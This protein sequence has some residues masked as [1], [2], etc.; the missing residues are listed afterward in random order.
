MRAQNFQPSTPG[1]CGW[2]IRSKEYFVTLVCI[3]SYGN[4]FTLALATVIIILL[5]FLPTPTNF[6]ADVSFSNQ[7]ML[8]FKCHSLYAHVCKYYIGTCSIHGYSDQ[9]TS[10]AKVTPTVSPT[11]DTSDFVTGIKRKFKS[12]CHCTTYLIKMN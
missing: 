9:I 4:Q 3:N 12:F 5:V 11:V 2:I 10:I 6:F 7:C 1:G 8:H